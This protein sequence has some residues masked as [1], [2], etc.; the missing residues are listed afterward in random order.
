[1]WDCIKNAFDIRGYNHADALFK[2]RAKS[3]NELAIFVYDIYDRIPRRY[4]TKSVVGWYEFYLEKTRG[5]QRY[6][7]DVVDFRKKGDEDVAIPA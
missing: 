6:I 3:N 7:Y 2:N 4:A 5:T 1:M